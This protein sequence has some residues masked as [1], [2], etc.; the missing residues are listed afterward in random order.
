M[1]ALFAANVAAFKLYARDKGNGAK[2]RN[3]NGLV[4]QVQEMARAAAGLFAFQ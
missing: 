1:Q 4:Q 2:D 3:N